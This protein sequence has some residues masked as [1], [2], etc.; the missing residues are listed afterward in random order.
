MAFYVSA[1]ADPRADK[2]SSPTH[3]YVVFTSG[4]TAIGPLIASFMV[5]Y[6]PG[7]WV[8]FSWLCMA[9]SSLCL[10]MMFFFYPES[11]FDQPTE[12]QTE[13]G[14]SRDAEH[15]TIA[16]DKETSIHQEAG[17]D[18]HSDHGVQ[19]LDHV[20]ID[21]VKVYTTVF[22]YDSS[23]KFTVAILRPVAFAA[24]PPVLWAILVYGSSLAAQVI[25]LYVPL[26]TPIHPPCA[27]AITRNS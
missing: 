1:K 17:S 14:H 26:S 7:T 2:T 16:D 10:V 27:Q 6:L 3:R 12:G 15:S 9:L 8:D 18:K 25:L 24:L 22:Q 19:H 23:L 21:W 13:R 11:N 4:A 20:D 5:T